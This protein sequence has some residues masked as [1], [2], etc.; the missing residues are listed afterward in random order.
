[1]E[2]HIRDHPEFA[3]YQV[4][5]ACLLHVPRDAVQDKASARRPCGDQRLPHHVEYDLVGHE[6]AAVEILL[7]GHAESALPRYMIAQQLPGRDVEDVEVRG[8]QCALG[9]FARAR[10]RDHQYSHAHLLTSSSPPAGRSVDSP[11]RCWRQRVQDNLV[12]RHRRPISTFATRER[13]ITSALGWRGGDRLTLTASAGVMVARRDP[14][15]MITVPGWPYIVIP[16]AVGAAAG[17]SQLE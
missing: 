14:D 11:A 10:R 3:T 16:P 8:D 4:E 15:G 13:A 7:N 1:M 17:G 6:F 2:R 5:R 12:V 9:P